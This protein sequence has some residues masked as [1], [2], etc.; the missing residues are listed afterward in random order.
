MPDCG[1]NE[2]SRR[3]LG[4]DGG[5]TRW[6][7]DAV[8]E[9]AAEFQTPL[10]D[11]LVC[12]LDAASRQHL[13]DHPQAQWEPEIQPDRVADEFGGEAI[14]SIKRVSEHR[15]PEPISDDLASAKQ[16]AA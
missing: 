15:H 10:P 8:G 3:C 11:R 16:E 4:W 2:T 12:D 5:R 7:S 9:F 6:R 13:L 1:R 14:A